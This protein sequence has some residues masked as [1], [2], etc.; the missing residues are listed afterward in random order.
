MERYATIISTGRYLPESEYS[1]AMMKA[2]LAAVSEKLPGVVDKFE[3][4]SGIKT[5]FRAAEGQVTSD[6]AAAAG[7]EAIRKAGLKPEDIDM[8]LLGTDSPDYITP[9][10]SVVTQYKIGAKNAGT[11]DIGCA[12][13]SFP[14]GVSTAAGLLAANHWMKYVLVIGSYLMSKLSDPNDINSFFYG[15]GEGAAVVG[16][17]EKPGFIAS[18][19]LSD[20]SYHKSWGIY[21]GGTYEPASVESVQ[22]GRTKVRL[23][24]RYP[25]EVNHDGWPNLMRQLAA[26]GGY[27]MQAVDMVIYTQVRQPSIVLVNELL[28]LPI[29]KAHW[30]MD[31]WGYT[32]SACIPMAL[33]DAVEQGKIHSGDLVCLIGSGV[34]YNQAGVALRWA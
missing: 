4:S 11:F 27:D 3:V 29:S 32:G 31:K 8:V 17:A 15:D 28:G 12:C 13:A 2:D 21:S 18:A 30:I 24:E 16:V 25:P 9:A 19:F 20:G 10:T 34:G 6:L 26:K 23:L 22:A 1:N 33:D 14:T 7:L 5:R